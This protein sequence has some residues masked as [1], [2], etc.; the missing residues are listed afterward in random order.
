MNVV[1]VRYAMN[2]MKRR[3]ICNSDTKQLVGIT[4]SL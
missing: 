3:N 1:Y 4:L 2:A